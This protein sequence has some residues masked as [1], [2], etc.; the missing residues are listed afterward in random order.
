MLK[1]IVL[2]PV[3]MDFGIVEPCTGSSSL[4]A[5]LVYTEPTFHLDNQQQF[6]FP[7]DSM[8][9]ICSFSIILFVLNNRHLQQR[10]DISDQNK[11]E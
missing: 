3:G 7:L 10:F 11:G 5:N 2:Q 9:R 4:I 6:V 8:M 1:A